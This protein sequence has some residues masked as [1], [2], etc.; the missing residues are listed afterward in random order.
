MTNSPTIGMKHRSDPATIPGIDNG[1]VMLQKARVGG[2]PRSW[3]A[4][5][6]VRSSFSR[7]A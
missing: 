1:R 5:I 4:S 7:V 3:A 6:S 2:Q